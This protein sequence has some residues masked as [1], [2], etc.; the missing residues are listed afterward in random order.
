LS[1][2]SAFEYPPFIDKWLAI[3]KSLPKLFAL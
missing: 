2:I 1:T 3:S